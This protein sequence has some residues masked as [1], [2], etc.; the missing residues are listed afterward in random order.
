MFLSNRRKSTSAKSAVTPQPHPST[1]TITTTTTKVPTSLNVPK[2]ESIVEET[3]PLEPSTPTEAATITKTTTTTTVTTVTTTTVSSKNPDNSTDINVNSLESDKCK[4]SSNVSAAED[5]RNI[6]NSYKSSTLQPITTMSPF[7]NPMKGNYDSSYIYHNNIYDSRPLINIV[8]AKSSSVNDV[9]KSINNDSNILGPPIINIVPTKSSLP[10]KIDQSNHDESLISVPHTLSNPPPS[11]NVP[12]A[13]SST[14][15]PVSSPLENKLRRNRSSTVVSTNSFSKPKI[16]AVGNSVTAITSEDT[17]CTKHPRKRQLKRM[18]SAPTLNI[19]FMPVTKN[20]SKTSSTKSM[21]NLNGLE[22]NSDR[23]TP[24]Q[25]L[26]RMMYSISRSKLVT[27]LAQKADAFHQSALKAYMESFEFE[28]VPIDLALRKLLMDCNLPKETQQIDRVI[29]AFAKRYHESNPDLFPSAVLAFSLLMLHTDAY[30]KSVRRKMTKEEFVK[31]TRIDGVNPEILEILYDNIT[32]A[33]FIYAQDD[34]DVNGQTMLESPTQHRQMKLFSSKERRK[35]TRPRND[36][37]WVIQTKLPTEFK[38]KIKDIVPTEN[39]YSYMGTL[40][41]LDIADLHRAFSAPHTIRIT[42]VQNRRKNHSLKGISGPFQSTNE[43]GTFLLKITKSG[44]LGRKVDL[45]DGKKKTGLRS[46]RIYGVILSGSQLMFFKDESGFTAQMKKLKNSEESAILPVLKPDVILMTADSVAVYDKNYEKYKNVFRLVCPKGHQYLFQ[47][48]NDAEMNDWISKINYA[49]TFKTAG[50]K[51]RNI[52]NPYV[53]QQRRGANSNGLRFGAGMFGLSHDAAAKESQ[54][55]VNLVRA[56]IDELQG[57]ISALTS[58]LQTDIRF[59]NN[60][61]LMIPYKASTRDR[62]L[63]V[64]TSVAS[65]LKHT[66]LELSRLVCYNEILE[67]DL[68]STVMEDKTYWQNRRS[69]FTPGDNSTDDSSFLF[70]SD[71]QSKTLAVPE[72]FGQLF[73]KEPISSSNKLLDPIERNVEN[74]SRPATFTSLPCGSTSSLSSKST[75]SINGDNEEEYDF[76]GNVSE[77]ELEIFPRNGSRND[78]DRDDISFRD[79]ASSIIILDDVREQSSLVNRNENEEYEANML[80][81]G[82]EYNGER[83]E[84]MGLLLTEHT[85]IA[86]TSLENKNESKSDNE[87]LVIGNVPKIQFE[88][89]Q[90][91]L[92]LKPESRPPTSL[93]IISNE[94]TVPVLV[95]SAV[96]EESKD[97]TNDGDISDDGGDQFVDAEEWGS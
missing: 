50:L 41:A 74:N 8:P 71:F 49:A 90:I 86:T 36:P 84:R 42:G 14:N 80:D 26:E 77:Y 21:T 66:C 31:N 67:K 38:P 48:E 30:N 1:K 4:N 7:K 88:V 13:S 28:K 69:Y 12:M 61:F 97:E 95:I 93:G 2:Q 23:E 64:A 68:C 45:I 22:A 5:M 34:T 62:I 55:R 10:V 44:K 19:P 63:Q 57:K 82:P 37:Y 59:R 11:S 89:P 35:S 3:K 51:M 15:P 79:D 58:Q 83:S 53:G 25:Y 72:T 60:L 46:W 18:G 78:E 6:P 87:T 81:A 75:L 96:E 76:Q 40:P 92:D 54:G 94:V 33:Q 73:V 91:Q 43:D 17:T 52:R 65:R 29:E 70:T 27:I 39:P 85:E 24:K 16:S 56:K 32:F 20:L 9:K 47:A